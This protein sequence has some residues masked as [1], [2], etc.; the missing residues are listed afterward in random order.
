MDSKNEI[1]DISVALNELFEKVEKLKLKLESLCKQ[2]GGCD[3][4]K[5]I[6]REIL[7]KKEVINGTHIHAF[8]EE[9]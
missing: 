7:K 3:H 6:N 4:I 9:E 8:R 2:T 5:A 1:K